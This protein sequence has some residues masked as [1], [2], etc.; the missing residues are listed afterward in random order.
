MS[1]SSGALGYDLYSSPNITRAIKS[2]MMRW[3]GLVARMGEMRGA[4][5]VLVGNLS[6]IDHLDDIGIDRR[7]LLK[8]IFKK[9]DG[10][11]D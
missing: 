3:A 1:A 11:L 5:R 7:I 10:G 6:E 2:R 8:W 4:C 9:E